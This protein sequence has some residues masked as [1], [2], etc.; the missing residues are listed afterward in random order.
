VKK[1]FVDLDSAGHGYAM[2]L[3]RLDGFQT[4]A[5]LCRLPKSLDAE[6]PRLRGR[7]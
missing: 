5:K 6:L 4:L 1:F 3:L 2:E 7:R